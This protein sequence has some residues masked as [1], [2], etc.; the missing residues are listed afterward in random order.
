MLA[1]R[2][3]DRRSDSETFDV[4]HRLKEFGVECRII[5]ECVD[6]LNRDRLR[7]AGAFSVVGPMRGYPEMIVRAIVAPGAERIV[8]RLF[9][10]E[11][12]ECL[13]FEVDL[14]GL[15]WASVAQAVLAE[16][17]GTAIGFTDLAGELHTNPRPD[18]LVSGKALYVLV[19]EAQM[20]TAN[21]IASA[22]E[23]VAVAQMTDE[24]RAE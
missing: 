6:D 3:G 24:L 17:S 23:R 13:R 19:D 21:G 10:S 15:T 1:E 8:E 11:V 5:A 18:T 16:N 22:L 9:S 2:E 12:D 14:T 7:N 4:I 20:P